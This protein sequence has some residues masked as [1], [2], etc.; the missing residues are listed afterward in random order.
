MRLD[1]SPTDIR[2]PGLVPAAAPPSPAERTGFLEQLRLDIADLRGYH[3]RERERLLGYWD[4]DQH[5][6]FHHNAVELL[7]RLLR[8]DHHC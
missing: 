4:A 7:D 3:A 5:I 2:V 8:L 6:S 1:P